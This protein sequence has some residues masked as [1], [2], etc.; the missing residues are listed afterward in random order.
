MVEVGVVVGVDDEEGGVALLDCF[1]AYFYDLDEY[2]EQLVVYVAFLPLGNCYFPESL[3]K[4][5]LSDIIDSHLSCPLCYFL[6]YLVFVKRSNCV[7]NL[8]RRV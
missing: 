4:S 8:A 5:H 1:Y 3:T 2:F 7:F 6:F